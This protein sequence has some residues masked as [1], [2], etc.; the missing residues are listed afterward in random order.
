MKIFYSD[1]LKI[2]LFNKLILYYARKFRK[3]THLLKSGC[4]N[5]QSQYI[6]VLKTCVPHI[7]ME[8]LIH[9]VFTKLHPYTDGGCI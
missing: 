9:F 6:K 4:N 8:T 7:L 1:F 3:L 5:D 2:G